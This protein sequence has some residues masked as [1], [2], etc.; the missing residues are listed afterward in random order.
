LEKLVIGLFTFKYSAFSGTSRLPAGEF[1]TADNLSVIGQLPG[2]V[3][4]GTQR[5]MG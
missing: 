5:E 3:P 4:I 1:V 2:V